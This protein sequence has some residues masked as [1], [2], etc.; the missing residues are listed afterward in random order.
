MQEKQGLNE[1][2]KPSHYF[3]KIPD[4]ERT[5]QDKHCPHYMEEATEA[6]VEL[7]TW[8]RFV[9]PASQRGCSR[10]TSFMFSP[11]TE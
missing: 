2:H 5:Y 10:R 6:G 4:L 11:L 9:N 1:H 8:L 3:C 7:G